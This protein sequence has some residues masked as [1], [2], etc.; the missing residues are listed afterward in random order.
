M[1]DKKEK[2]MLL[3]A[4]SRIENSNADKTKS[5]ITLPP[6]QGQK[7]PKNKENM[8]EEER[9]KEEERE[10][11]VEKKDLPSREFL[12]KRVKIS[13]IERYH[14]DRVFR[15]LHSCRKGND[16]QSSAAQ[17]KNERS[18]EKPDDKS[19]ERGK[20]DSKTAKNKSGK[21]KPQKEEKESFGVEDV[22][23]ILRKAAQKDNGEDGEP[24][25][26]REE[27]EWMIWVRFH[28]INLGLI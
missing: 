8:T 10:M 17:D 15:L 9:K 7:R 24:I 18:L 5:S 16:Q 23:Y 25:M 1:T 4:N 26:S 6:V 11:K 27:V 12:E 2:A 20:D 22:M 3:T 21:I 14:L 13:P 19:L 28:V